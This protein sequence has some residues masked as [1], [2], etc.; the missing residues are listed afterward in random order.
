MKWWKKAARLLKPHSQVL[1]AAKNRKTRRHR[2]RG[3]NEMQP[4]HQAAAISEKLH[5]TAQQPKSEISAKNEFNPRT[6]E[7]T[8]SPKPD[9]GED[10]AGECRKPVGCDE[11]S[12][13]AAAESEESAA[14]PVHDFSN[15]ISNSSD[16]S[17][18]LRRQ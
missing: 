6:S 18:K 9:N 4:A 7:T 14:A 11:N 8:Q 5:L 2:K 17:Q 15:R 1:A 13:F 3:E 16:N 10:Q 12:R